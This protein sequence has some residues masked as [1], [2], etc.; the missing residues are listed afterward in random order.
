MARYTVR[1]GAPGAG[2]E[3]LPLG[4]HNVR[5][6][7]TVR[8]GRCQPVGRLEHLPDPA[9]DHLRRIQGSA[10]GELLLLAT[11][12]PE[13]VPRG[14]K[15]R[16]D[17]I[18]KGHTHI[19]CQVPSL[20]RSWREEA[21]FTVERHRGDG[22]WKVL[23]VPVVPRAIRRAPLASAAAGDDARIVDAP[24][25]RCEP[26]CIAMKRQKRTNGSRD[27]REPWSQACCTPAVDWSGRRDSN[28]RPPEPH[29]GAL[30]GCA[31]S[32]PAPCGAT[33]DC[34]SGPVRI[35]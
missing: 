6:R 9:P 34:T 8:G 15:T 24:G 29:S 21:G 16:D 25:S 35:A 3:R 28:S 17:A 32:R 31:T 22:R 30:P 2:H 7:P 1:I 13:Y 11:P 12:H 23:Y 14:L 4:T 20:W 27:A 33:D 10:P 5:G 26:D 19:N 18:G